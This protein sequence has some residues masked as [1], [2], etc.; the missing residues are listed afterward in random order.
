MS[1]ALASESVCDRIHCLGCV[2]ALASRIN[3]IRIR[4]IVDM[5][6][7]LACV[8]SSCRYT[9]GHST[10]DEGEDP[11]VFAQPD[12]VLSPGGVALFSTEHMITHNNRIRELRAARRE[13]PPEEEEE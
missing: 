13:Y 6:V 9:A 12:T 1:T 7:C 5:D 11:V 10:L 3:V 2:S 8:R 4:G